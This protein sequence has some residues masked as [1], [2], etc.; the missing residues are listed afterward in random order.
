MIIEINNDRTVGEIQEQF[1][2]RF[3]LL[4][5][6]FFPHAHQ[7]EATSEE[8]PCPHDQFIGEIRKKNVHGIIT[9]EPG[10]ETGDLEKEFERRFGLN[11]QV[12]RYQLDKWIQTAGTDI[13]LLG[14]QEQIARE[15]S[16]FYNPDHEQQ[17]G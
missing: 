16:A 12:Y 4:K 3:P 9:I 13:L 8:M 2:A 11:V 5:L 17:K 15:S 7:R 14:E 6:E 1:T 10:R